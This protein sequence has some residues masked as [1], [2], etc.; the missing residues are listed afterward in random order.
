MLYPLDDGNN[1]T[2]CNELHY[3]KTST[4]NR[5]DETTKEGDT[6]F[7]YAGGMMPIATNASTNDDFKHRVKHIRVGKKREKIASLSLSLSLKDTTLSHPE[8]GETNSR[9]GMG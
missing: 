5:K 9:D 1:T 7:V 6:C 4:P 8:N 3:N 2:Q